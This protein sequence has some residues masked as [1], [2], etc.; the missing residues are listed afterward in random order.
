MSQLWRKEHLCTALTVVQ[1][2]CNTDKALRIFF[3]KTGV[4]KTSVSAC[5]RCGMYAC[6]CT[7]DRS[8]RSSGLASIQI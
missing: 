8:K 6:A 1:E 3:D 7:I 4:D 5:R 2:S